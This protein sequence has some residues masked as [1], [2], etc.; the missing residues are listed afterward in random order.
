MSRLDIKQE[1][2]KRFCIL[3]S[4]LGKY[5]DGNF[6]PFKNYEFIYSKGRATETEEEADRARDLPSTGSKM[7]ILFSS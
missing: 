4:E 2:Y 1:S 7:E 5:K 6:F 3:E